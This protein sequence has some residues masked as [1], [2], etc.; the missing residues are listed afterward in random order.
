[1][2]LTWST[3]VWIWLQTARDPLAP[4][5]AKSQSCR[6]QQQQWAATTTAHTTFGGTLVYWANKA[7]SI[8]FNQA[9]MCTKLR[10]NCATTKDA[11][12]ALSSPRLPCGMCNPFQHP[13][14]GAQ[15]FDNEI[16][17]NEKLSV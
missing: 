9:E 3:A 4:A 12:P 15:N 11:T 17:E 5:M 10:L 13:Q 8:L 6:S 14:N 1:M 2:L 16:G 7:T